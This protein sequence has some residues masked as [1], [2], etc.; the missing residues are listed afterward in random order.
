M[1]L[2]EREDGGGAGYDLYKI[3]LKDI[4]LF[5]TFF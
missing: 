3:Q 1:G 2:D 4:S 5:K